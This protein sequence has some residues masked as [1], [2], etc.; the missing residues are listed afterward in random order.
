M[1]RAVGLRV[2]LSG[3]CKAAIRAQELQVAP[4]PKVGV[5]FRLYTPKCLF[6]ILGAMGQGIGVWVCG[7]ED[8]AVLDSEDRA[9]QATYLHNG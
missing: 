7:F 2:G 9:L 5:I 8:A 3:T 4:Q 1:S 6:C